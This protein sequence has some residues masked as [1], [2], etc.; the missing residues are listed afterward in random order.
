MVI[1]YRATW[2]DE[3]IIFTTLGEMRTRVREEKITR[4]AL[5]FVGRVFG[6]EHFRDSRLYDAGFTHVLRNAG[7]KKLRAAE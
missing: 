4:T 5:I 7:K 2:P 3:E 6:A 1:V